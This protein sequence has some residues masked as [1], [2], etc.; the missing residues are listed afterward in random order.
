MMRHMSPVKKP[1]FL[2]ERALLASGFKFIAGV[3]EAGM[4]CLAG[5]V[6]AA[7]VI[8]PLNSRIGLIRDSKTL[9][10]LQRE[11]IIDE[12]KMK[13]VAWAVGRASW[14]E[15]DELNIRGAGALA[16]KRAVDGLGTTPDFILTDAFRIPDITLP[17][18]NVIRGDLTVK[19]IAAA[20]IIAKVDR[21]REMQILDGKYPGYGFAKHKGYGTKIHKEALE[22]L[23]PSPVHR[24]SYAPVKRLLQN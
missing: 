14:Q 16:M 24:M 10:V 23:G 18:K 4:G 7:A 12:I 2:E 21:D 19:S 1:T 20:S 11:S 3:D 15:V 17:Q 6:Y 9:S 22:R 13:A 8:L 5:P